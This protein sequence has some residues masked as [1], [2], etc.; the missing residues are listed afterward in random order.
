MEGRGEGAGGPDEL[1]NSNFK[2]ISRESSS[3]HFVVPDLVSS[4]ALTYNKI[5]IVSK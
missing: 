3:R 2:Y 5:A 4:V 1:V